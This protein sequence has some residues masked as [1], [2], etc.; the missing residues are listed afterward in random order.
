MLKLAKANVDTFHP[1]IDVR[2]WL[3]RDPKQGKEWSVAHDKDAD[4]LP[5]QLSVLRMDGF[6]DCVE[7]IAKKII[8]ATP[9]GGGGKVWILFCTAGQHR[10]DGVAKALASRVFNAG[11]DDDRRYN[12]NVF[13]LSCAQVDSYEKTIVT[14]TLRWLEQPWCDRRELVPWAHQ[15]LV[16]S[17]DAFDVLRKIDGVGRDLLSRKDAHDARVERARGSRVETPTA[18]WHRDEVE[19]GDKA[20]APKRPK[21]DRGECV[22]TTCPFCGGTGEYQPMPKLDTIETW[23][24]ILEMSE[25]DEPARQDWASLFAASANGKREALSIVHKVISKDAQIRK[26]SMWVTSAVRKA[27]HEVRDTPREVLGDRRRGGEPRKT[28]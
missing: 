17:G 26:P 3:R 23:S 2:R 14:Q 28:R 10:S 11:A 13:S 24:R 18:P 27:W 19:A 7:S 22:D 8:A 25:V 1:P 4:F 20:P 21:V 12:C 15:A 16:V 6:V 5:C 9:S